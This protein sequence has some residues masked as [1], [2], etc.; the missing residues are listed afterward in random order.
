MQ[1]LQTLLAKRETSVMVDFDHL[2]HRVRCYAHIINICCSHI[3]SS[4][5]SV[6]EQYLSELDI[7]ID[8]NPVFCEGDDSDDDDDDDGDVDRVENVAELELDNA[9]DADD[10]DLQRWFTGIRRDPVKRARRMIRFLRASDLR[11]QGL[12]DF[13]KTGNEQGWF[14]QKVEDGSTVPVTIKNVQLLR[15]VKTRWDS[16]YSMLERL[17]H[18]RPVSLFVSVTGQCGDESTV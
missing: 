5:T 4:V 18:L 15:D 14:F 2:K 1:E 10:P 8:S 17:L 12:H 7:P 11:R 3:I 16:V 9:F 6:P 13:I